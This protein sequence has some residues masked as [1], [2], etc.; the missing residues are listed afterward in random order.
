MGS[1]IEKDI[2]YL[3]AIDGLGEDYLETEEFARYKEII[4]ARNQSNLAYD[5]VYTSD[6]RAIPYVNTRKM[7]ISKGRPL[8]TGDTDVCVVSELFTETYGLSVGD[9]LHI[10]LGDK[11]LQGQ[12]QYGTRYRT[13]ENL[14]NF[15]TS[16]DLEI[17]GVY[18]FNN[19]WIERLNDYNWSYG[20]ATIFVPTSLLPVEIPKDHEIL[21]G[22]CS[23]FIEDPHDIEEFRAAAE[24]MAAKM[25][26]ALHYSDGGWSGIKD[27]LDTGALASL[28]TTVLYV[29]GAALALLLAV[30]LYIDRN[31][32]SY[33]IMR[34]LGVPGKKAGISVTLPLIVLSIISL[35]IGSISGLYYA[36]YTAAKTLANISGDSAPEGYI[37]VLNAAIPLGVVFF[38]LVLELLFIFSMTLLFLWK[39]K[40]TPPLELLLEHTDT[41]KKAGILQNC[42]TDPRYKPDMADMASVPLEFDTVKLSDVL[43]STNLETNRATHGKYR[44]PQQVGAYILRHMHRGI[45]KTVGALLLTVILAAGIG[46]FVL[47]RLTYQEAYHQ[48]N[49][50][51]RAMQF[52]SNY[53]TELSKS[54]L[55]KDIYYYNNY[56]VR[57]NGVGVLS[58][59]TFTN[60]F[61]QYL[62]DDYTVTYAKGY[63]RSVFE[64]TGAVCFVG[65]KLAETLG[66]HAGDD[67]TLM[68]EDLYSFMPQIYEEDELEFAIERAGKSYKIAGILHSENADE[69][70]GI[71]SIINEAAEN[72]YSQPFSVDY[73]GIH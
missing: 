61:D 12:G 19:E 17:I 13:A 22:D 30:Y 59:M 5:I 26:L 68:S 57:V 37:Y 18:Q 16:V 58:P 7:A 6:M 63:D 54:D 3:R 29:L 73:C 66:V 33:A 39:M 35:P 64:G 60:D 46:M 42:F 69:N 2:D 36:S 9:T 27:N 32:K 43:T 8:T 25:G 41:P 70:A 67:I 56:R 11:L 47:A 23:V 49:V 71:Y 52:S 55:I 10:E 24:L 1:Y 20:P 51:G 53:I 45:G 48:L 14:S 28:L 38:C 40:K 62:T 50:K 31:K 34:T 72:L 65:Q 15:I 4:E 44:A 21:M